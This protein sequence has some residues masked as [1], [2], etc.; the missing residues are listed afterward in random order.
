MQGVSVQGSDQLS[1]EIQGQ[2]EGEKGDSAKFKK[3]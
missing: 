2:K 3:E 1:E